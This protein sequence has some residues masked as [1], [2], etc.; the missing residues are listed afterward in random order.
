MHRKV[1]ITGASRGI[2]KAIALAFAEP[3]AALW[4]NYRSGHTQA[5]QVAA[6]CRE[7][8]ADVRLVPFDVGA[9][10]AVRSALEPLLAT[11]GYV[12]VLVNNAGVTRDGLLPRL[13][14]SDWDLVLRTNLSGIHYVTQAA[15]PGMIRQRKGRIINLT[16][17]SGERGNA[18]QT[19]YCAAKAGVIGF[20]KSLAYEVGSRGITVNA[21]SPG[22]IETDMTSQLPRPELE[23]VIALR[24]Y[25]RPEEVAAAV[26]FLASE[27]ASYITGQVISVNGGLYT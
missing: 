3:G 6:T 26:Y 13:S 2:G 18:G 9:P 1:L 21:V 4:L 5:E 8:G 10:E 23:K 27:G 15:V 17:V 25:G 16:S 12:D 24:R 19:N 11:Q 20:T 7:R 22:I 14:D